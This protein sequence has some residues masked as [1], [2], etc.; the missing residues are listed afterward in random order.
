MIYPGFELA[1]RRQHVSA[2]YGSS[3]GS[4]GDIFGAI[5][6]VL[7]TPGTRL[8]PYKIKTLIGCRTL[9]RRSPFPVAGGGTQVRT[10]RLFVTLAANENIRVGTLFDSIATIVAILRM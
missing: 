3:A 1:V 5:R 2:K 8:G 6:S 9:P 4:L 7:L 10:I